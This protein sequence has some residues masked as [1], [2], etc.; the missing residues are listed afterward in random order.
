ME[1]IAAFVAGYLLGARSAPGRLD[2]LARAWRALC[3]T[4]EFAALATAVRRHVAHTLRELAAVCDVP[5][6]GAAD[7]DLV[8]RVRALFERN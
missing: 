6:P 7:D 3:D 2:E 1:L 8:G 5:R 4:E